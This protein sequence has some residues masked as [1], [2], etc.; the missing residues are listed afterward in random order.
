MIY[1]FHTYM[2]SSDC[3]RLLPTVSNFYYDCVHVCVFI[4]AIVLHFYM[5]LF[6]IQLRIASLNKKLIKFIKTTLNSNCIISDGKMKYQAAK[7]G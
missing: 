5:S 1:E 3:K 2:Y 7:G 4:E 6:I